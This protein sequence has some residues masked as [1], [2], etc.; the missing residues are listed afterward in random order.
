MKRVEPEKKSGFGRLFFSDAV[1][2]I[3][4]GG[5]VESN[6]LYWLFWSASQWQVAANV[7]TVAGILLALAAGVIA[8]VSYRDSNRA[9]EN[10]HIHSLFND[11]LRI[12]FDHRLH[13]DATAHPG[14][15]APR[16]I[17]GPVEDEVASIK[18]YV[19]EEM[20]V[21]IDRQR[22]D[23]LRILNWSPASRRRLEESLDAWEETILSHVD[24]DEKMVLTSIHFFTPCYSL[25][26]L[27]FLAGHWRHRP[28]FI[29][30]VEQQRGQKP[31]VA[32]SQIGKLNDLLREMKLKAPS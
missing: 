2:I 27:E 26:F 1:V 25:G 8:F 13:V 23:P 9:A 6:K 3:Q 14:G 11:Y 22:R 20:W 28:R 7:A 29:A 24:D 21:W 10:A 17:S 18:L 16:R 15:A 12:R 30:M 32:H 31:R 19:L 4:I 5:G